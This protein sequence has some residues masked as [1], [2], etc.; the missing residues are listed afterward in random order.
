MISQP[1]RGV[2]TSR[3]K[4]R[5]FGTVR[6]SERDRVGVSMQGHRIRVRSVLQGTRQTL[7]MDGLAFPTPAHEDVAASV[8]DFFS[9]LT[10]VDAVLVIASCARGAA[11]V[12]SDLD[13]AVLVDEMMSFAERDALLREWQDS[14][15]GN[16]ALAELDASGPLATLHLDIVDGV[17]EPTEWDDGGGPDDFEVESGNHVAYSVA[18]WDGTSHY[19]ALRARWLPYYD[20]TLRTERLD[21]VRSACLY[22]LTTVPVYAE[23]GLH[24][25]AFDRL[26]KAFREF[27]QALFIARGV[28]PIAYNK[29]I[30]YQLCDVLAEPEVYEGVR[31]IL[32]LGSHENP[33]AKADRL[34]ELLD[35]SIRGLPQA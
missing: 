23:R 19:G 8:V 6:H 3:A 10:A 12:G 34:A 29:W 18:L 1:R 21:M 31:D 20:E 5:R 17:Y 14:A 32:V 22:D 4:L 28:Y 30:R 7:P 24:F 16:L 11:V 26:Y 9:T 15:R 27:L 25:Q 33:P 2:A 13:M 35:R